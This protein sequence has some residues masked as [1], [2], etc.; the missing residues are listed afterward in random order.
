[1]YPRL[2]SYLRGRMGI[3]QAHPRLTA[4]TTLY[5]LARLVLGAVTSLLLARWMGPDGRGT[6][7]AALLLPSL[8]LAVGGMGLAPAF[9]FFSASEKQERS[10]L[11]STAIYFA[12]IQSAILW[13][14]G[15]ALIDRL[16]SSH[17]SDLTVPAM[18]FLLVIPSSALGI[19]FLGMLLGAGEVSLYNRIGLIIPVGYLVAAIGLIARGEL[20]VMSLV[21]AQIGLN[22]GVVFFCVVALRRR[23][24]RL[25]QYGPWTAWPVLLRVTR[26]GLKAQLRDASTAINMRLDQLVIAALL[27]PSELAY[28]AVAASVA[29]VLSIF[30]MAL[31]IVN[32]PQI[33][34]EQ[35][36]RRERLVQSTVHSLTRAAPPLW[37]GAMVFL[38][39]GMVFILGPDWIPALLPVGIL[40][41]AGVILGFKDLLSACAAACGDPWLASRA[42]VA[43]IAVTALGLVVLVPT[44]GI[45]GAA[46]TSLVSYSVAAGIM[47]LGFRS[48]LGLH[49]FEAAEKRRFRPEG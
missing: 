49:V 27:P 32:T 33:A 24:I 25:L 17:G 37:L 14:I 8:L 3:I 18:V 15:Y 47:I 26:F 44:M 2:V 16:Y 11:A 9:L 45:V 28:Y 5:N 35:G 29:S 30:P 22:I 6:L 42:E 48:R 20:D 43:G 21:V 19:Y 46:L 36:S 23:G 41:T 1:M 39:L 13:P 31:Q 12:T 40:I 38:P 10:Q 34:A 4:T 7:A